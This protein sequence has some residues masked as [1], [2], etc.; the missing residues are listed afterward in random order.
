MFRPNI[1]IKKWMWFALA[2][3][4]TLH[5]YFLRELLAAELLFGMLF[6]LGLLLAF[7]FFL[8]E[9]VGGRGMTWARPHAQE[10]AGGAWRRLGQL[11]EISKK[12]YR[13]LRSESA[14]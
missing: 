1:K 11:E 10:L 12:S 5:V 7:V 13:R 4:I 8:V 9:E 14:R 3:V 6:A 2:A